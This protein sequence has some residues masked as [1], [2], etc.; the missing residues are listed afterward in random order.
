[1]HRIGR[2]PLF[3]FDGQE[4]GGNPPPAE[5]KTFS[6][7]QVDRMIQERLAR[8]KAT[9]PADY[10]QLQ[11]TAAEQAT[12]L[13]EI[14]AANLTELQKAQK[15]AADAEAA[16]VALET[17]TAGQVTKAREAVLNAELKAAAAS[18]GVRAALLG[19]VIDRTSVTVGDD[20]AVTGLAEAVQAAI[21]ANPE[22]VGNKKT[23]PTP[24]AQMDGGVRPTPP[25]GSLS[26]QVAVA[27]AQGDLGA[28][29]RLKTQQALALSKPAA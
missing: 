20:G 6:Q 21:D 16:R 17:A 8:A 14:E 27:E 4:D 19:A 18:A 28:A 11:K 24:I 7:E 22:I 23:P 29:M 3:V 10:E 25:V 13:A 1:M 5:P 2:L 12:R 9:P 26:D 15:A